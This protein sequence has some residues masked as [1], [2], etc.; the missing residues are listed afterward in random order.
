MSTNTLD[1]LARLHGDLLAAWNRRDAAGMARLYAP[2]GGQVGF[3]G[4]IAN[5]PDEIEAQLAP[6]FRDHPTGRFVAKVREVRAVGDGAA[7]LRAVA[8]M[9]PP[10]KEDINPA[11]NAIQGLV[12]SRGGDGVWRIEL[13]QNTP[14]QFHG[15]PA[16]QER[17]T[18][19]LR[20]LVK[21]G[22]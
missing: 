10:G 13:F 17:L 7:L 2:Q 22:G 8:G 21:T 4:S 9:I 3:D 1:A 19:E 6:I 18:E 14:A 16:E 12:A 20:R 11:L 15:R 5:G